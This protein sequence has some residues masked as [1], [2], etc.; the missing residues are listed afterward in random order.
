[1]IKSAILI[2]LVAFGYYIYTLPSPIE[3]PEWF[4]LGTLPT[5]PSSLVDLAAD[6]SR[7]ELL[8]QG[9]LKG[10]ESIEFDTTGRIYLSLGNGSIVRSVEPIVGNNEIKLEEFVHIGERV[11]ECGI[12]EMEDGKTS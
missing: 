3:N 6:P 11:P 9:K 10:P 1:M 7:V 2:V 4:D 5:L 12:D 8:F